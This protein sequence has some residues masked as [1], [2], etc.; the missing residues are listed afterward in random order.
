MILKTSTPAL[1]SIHNQQLMSLPKLKINGK[2]IEYVE[3]TKVLGIILDNQLNFMAHALEKLKACNKKWA[4]ITRGTNRN[5]GLNIRSLL[6]LLRTTVL[7]KL[8]YAAPLWLKKNIDL[9]TSFWN[10]VLMKISGSMLYPQREITEIA[11]HLPPLEIQLEGITAKFMCKVLA[12][13]DFLTPIIY[14]IDGT[15]KSALHGQILSLKRFLMWKQNITRGLQ[16]MDISHPEYADLAVYTMKE[17]QLYQQ[18]IWLEAVENRI[19]HKKSVQPTKRKF[20]E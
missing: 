8:L 15:N 4:F 3:K 7:T 20:T 14:Q 19:K 17:I 2:E 9:Y 11:L 6:L 12:G 5:H 16:E 1:N 13:N 18:K 10:R